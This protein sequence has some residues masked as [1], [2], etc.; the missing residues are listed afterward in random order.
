[1]PRIRLAGPRVPWIRLREPSW[2]SKVETRLETLTSRIYRSPVGCVRDYFRVGHGRRAQTRRPL[3][4]T[5]NAT[6]RA[7]PH[8]R[9]GASPCPLRTAQGPWRFAPNRQTHTAVPRQSPRPRQRQLRV[10]IQCI[11][12]H[13]CIALLPDTS[14]TVLLVV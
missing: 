6:H 14:R 4:C 7:A 11:C 8:G 5:I 10:R 2:K 12:V 1:M 3:T 13:L 9:T